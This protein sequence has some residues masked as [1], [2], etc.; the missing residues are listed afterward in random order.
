MDNPPKLRWLDFVKEA[1]HVGLA[2]LRVDESALHAIPFI[3][4]C[5]PHRCL[6]PGSLSDRFPISFQVVSG[7]ANHLSSSKDT[8]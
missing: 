3:S 1:K 4:L 6:L 7:G 8:K 2:R 5:F